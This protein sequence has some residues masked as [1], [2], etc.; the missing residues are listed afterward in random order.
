M[1]SNRQMNIKENFLLLYIDW[2]NNHNSNT[3]S[4]QN[5]YTIHSAI[6]LLSEY[7]LRTKKVF[8]LIRDPFIAKHLILIACPLGQNSEI[9]GSLFAHCQ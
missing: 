3:R 7:K 2:V 1:L 8:N 4:D 6:H 5:C 9:G